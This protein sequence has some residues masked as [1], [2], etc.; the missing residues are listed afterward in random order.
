MFMHA[1]GII[2]TGFFIVFFSLVRMQCN[3]NRCTV[4]FMI[5]AFRVEILIFIPPWKLNFHSPL[6]AH[7]IVSFDF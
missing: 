6:F 7:I 2:F 1:I 5:A 3:G 4:L